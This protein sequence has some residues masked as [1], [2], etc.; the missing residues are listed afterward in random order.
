[1]AAIRERAPGILERLAQVLAEPP[2]LTWEQVWV[3]W[4]AAVVVAG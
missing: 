3:C 4:K 2:V 1:M